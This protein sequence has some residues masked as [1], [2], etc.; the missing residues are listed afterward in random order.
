MLDQ[1]LP[2]VQ[3]ERSQ[4]IPS[5]LEELG[6]SRQ[7]RG[8]CHRRHRCPCVTSLMGGY[9]GGGVSGEGDDDRHEGTT[10]RRHGVST[11]RSVS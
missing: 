10:A 6:L 4:R 11:R 9:E 7:G 2:D 8:D 1:V 3:Q 5:G